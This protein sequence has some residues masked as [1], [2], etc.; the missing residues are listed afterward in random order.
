MISVENL[1][2]A[3]TGKPVLQDVSFEVRRGE[4]QRGAKIPGFVPDDPFDPE[5]FNRRYHGRR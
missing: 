5:I 1:S 3:Y 2:F 4:I